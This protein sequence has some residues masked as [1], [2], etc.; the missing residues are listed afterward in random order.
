MTELRKLTT[1]SWRRFLLSPEGVEAMLYLRE[2]TP[3]IDK[4]VDP[5]SMIFEAG[6]CQGYRNCL[7]TISE[8]IAKEP[9]KSE[10]LENE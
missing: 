8:I 6:R 9:T 4:G 1:I 5:Y 10:S 2:R 3:S 7:D